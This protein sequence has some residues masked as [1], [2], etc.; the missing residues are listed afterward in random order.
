MR[1]SAAV[2]SAALDPSAPR[3]GAAVRFVAYVVL[4]LLVVLL[5]VFAAEGAV[6]LRQWLKHGTTASFSQ[7]YE[8]DERIGLR[9]LKPNLRIGSVTTNA[10]G[11]RGPEIAQPKPVGTVRLAFL[12]ASTTYCAEVSGDAMVWPQLVA[13]ELRRRFP[14]TAFDFVNG[15]VP[16]YVVASSLKNLRHRVAALEP[17]IVVVYH[18][19]NDL[20]GEVNRRAQQAGLAVANNAGG[21]SWLERHSLLWELA[22]KNL[23][24]RAALSEGESGQNRLRL[25]AKDLGAEFRRDLGSLLQEARASGARVAVATFATHLRSGQ[26]AQQQER[27]AVSALVYMPSMTPDGLLA[28][29]ARYNELIAEAARAQGALLIGGEDRIPGDPLHFVDSVH[30]TDQGSR[31]MAARVIDA[32]HADP[33]VRA[34]IDRHR[35]R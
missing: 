8:T 14:G 4:P 2:P 9:V 24:V 35:Q 13:D 12:G 26:S 19:T 29:Y 20:S 21:P 11:F 34:L 17:D 31:A 30:F 1:P 6:R 3:A 33:T 32:L 10:A 5:L 16:G 28:G 18:A 22:L 7:L 23:R 15:G 25:D 27:A